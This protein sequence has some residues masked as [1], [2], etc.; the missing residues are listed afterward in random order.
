MLQM[1]WK[2]QSL[3]HLMYFGPESCLMQHEWKMSHDDARGSECF[4]KVTHIKLRM[5]PASATF[6]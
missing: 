2:V 6:P 4:P 3:S 1:L 5:R